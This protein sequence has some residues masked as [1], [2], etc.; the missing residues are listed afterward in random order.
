M[1]AES[2]QQRKWAFGAKGKAWAKKH[3]FDNKGRL[4][5]HLSRKSEH[6]DSKKKRRKRVVPP[7]KGGFW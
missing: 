4:P 3:H 6:L 2:E 1:P 5:D 7:S